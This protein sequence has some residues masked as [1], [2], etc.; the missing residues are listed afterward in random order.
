M[1]VPCCVLLSLPA[2]WPYGVE[3]FPLNSENAMAFC[4]QVELQ[5]VFYVIEPPVAKMGVL[6]HLQPPN[7]SKR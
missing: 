6:S 5:N 1:V 7:S 3:N 4:V 2:L